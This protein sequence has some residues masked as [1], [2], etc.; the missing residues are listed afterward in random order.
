MREET[1]TR[2]EYTQHL[3]ERYSQWLHRIEQVDREEV[4]A[5][6][7]ELAGVLPERERIGH[8]QLLEE[9]VKL[10]EKVTHLLW[11]SEHLKI[12]HD[13]SHIFAK[14]F[15][16][17]EILW[18][19]FELVS[20]VMPTDAF[21]IAFYDE[22]DS[23][24]R[25]PISVDNGVNYGPLTLPY[26]KGLISKVLATRQTVHLQ[27]SGDETEGASVRWGNPDSDTNACIF[28]PLMLDNQIKGVISAQSYREFAY[29]KE[30]EEL[31][32]IIGFQVASAIET[33]RLYDRMYQMSFQDELSGILNYRAFHRDLEQL[34]KSEPPSVALV[35]LDSD[36]LKAVNDQYGHHLGDA[37]IRRI[38][39]ALKQS[40]SPGDSVYRYAG[41]EFMLLSPRATL[42][43][44]MAKVRAIREYLRLH[45]LVH[46]GRVIPVTVSVGIACYPEHANTADGL[47]RAA[48]EA[49]YRS[50]HNGKNC[51]TVYGTA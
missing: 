23:E 5:L 16:E 11:L 39:E 47:K 29:K 40:A 4:E 41:D 13:L 33:A 22:G 17:E 31:L 43:E 19:A 27:T 15:E 34:L 44:A 35:M 32:A 1:S 2:E 25:I 51:A 20:R 46:E 7:R 14:T 12:L 9:I 49:L 38:A 36:H 10:N 26:G 3:L 6:S 48:D 30:H 21:L 28:V 18:R 8:K 42:E 50:K 37:L 45:P 24:I